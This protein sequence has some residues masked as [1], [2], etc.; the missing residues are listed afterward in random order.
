[1]EFTPEQRAAIES[2]GS[3]VVSAGA[4]SGKTRVLVER[5]LR[6]IE[7][8]ANST[9]DP[10]TAILA[11][12]F[13]EKAAREMRER[14]RQ[15]VEARAQAGPPEE[16]ARWEAYSGAVEGA[17]IAT[18]HSFCGELLRA[19]PAESGID[20]RFAVLDEVEAGLLIAECVEETLRIRSQELESSGESPD[21]SALSLLL[22]E[23]TPSE[24]RATLAELLQGGG[25]VRA[26]LL[27]LPATPDA[28][29]AHWSARLEAARSE[30]L[31][32]LFSGA[33]WREA[34]AT[35]TALAATAP[36]NDKLGGQL[37]EVARWLTTLD[38]AAP[39]FRIIAGLDLRGGSKKAWGNEAAL[40]SARAALRAL[41]DAYGAAAPLLDFTPEPAVERRAAAVVLALRELALA[42]D[43]AYSHAKASRDQLDFDDLERRARELLERHPQV[44]AR[45]QAELRAVLVD[46]FQDTNDDQ[47]AIIYALAGVEPEPAT[48][49]QP[50]ATP[51]GRQG[52]SAQ[53][54][55]ALGRSSVIGGSSSLFVVGDGK[56]SIYRFR[57]ADVSVFQRVESEIQRWGGRRVTLQTTFRTHAALTGLI[58]QVSAAIFARAEPLQPFEVPFEA[59]TPHRPPPPHARVAEL[60][61]V[62]G[63]GSAEERREAEAAALVA[64]IKALVAGAEGPIVYEGGRWRLPTYGD[65]ALLF[66]ASTAFEPFEDALRREGIPYLTTAGRGYYG[67]KE[68]QDLIHLLRA[69]DDPADELALV[70]ALRSPLFALDDGTIMALRL[71]NSRSIWEALMSSEVSGEHDESSKPLNAPSSPLTFARDVLAELHSLR[72]RVTVVE[73]L[74]AALERTGYLATV[75]A[76]E[77]GERR[78]ANIE[79]L[80]AAARLSGAK[81]LRAFSE[82]LAR[83]LRAET[84][85]GEAPLEARGAVRLMT[86]HRS[87]GLEFPIVA[88]P[89]LGRSTPARRERWF[90][91]RSYGLAVRLRE[92]G[93]ETA[94][95]AALLLA[96]R[97][98]A[99]ME[100]AERER[101]LYVAMTRAQDYLLLSGPAQTKGGESWISRVAAAL[102]HPWENGGPPHGSIGALHVFRH[103]LN[104]E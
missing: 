28:L 87:K 33:P 82:Y 75:S 97:A 85:E 58:N 93:E 10:F 80:L 59:L 70:G 32:A 98:E 53:Q 61:I 104:G 95:P 62:A 31:K 81:G 1:M 9:P 69:L 47:R 41:R 66:Q 44:R 16:R 65:V 94:Q 6:L 100:Q 40:A 52:P 3:L 8:I 51:D 76:L 84:R 37:L 89:D 15:T 55:V 5:Y 12:T 39:D 21:A 60:H 57:G 38:Q 30:A 27:S 25:E 83:L 78:R 18:I 99:R 36:P 7:A 88:L 29:V 74:R 79:K 11:V 90:A 86:I 56:Q 13:T 19:H 64:R 50:P 20:P 22:E 35:V 23:F 2:D 101:L 24:L 71:A 14:V 68:V 67:R 103:D 92:E 54:N 34:A 43:A 26:A 77:D 17:R 46:E 4:G 45:W 73:L 102:G 42:A 96:R 48:G 49:H 72:G 91:G 63:G